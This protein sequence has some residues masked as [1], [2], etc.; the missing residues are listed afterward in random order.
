MMTST[1]TRR[2]TVTLL[3]H[4]ES[5]FNRD[6][7]SGPDAAITPQGAA[8]AST[9]SGDYD[10][11]LV[12]AMRRARETWAASG[13]AATR[14]EF[15]TLA[16]ERQS[17]T[18]CNGLEGEKGAGEDDEAFAFRMRQ[19]WDTILWLG[20]RHDRILALTGKHVGNCQSITLD[21]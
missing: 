8:Q 4:A 1:P 13:I 17:K 11:A 10:Y 15:T 19:L 3:R 5:T 6:G 9:L 7:E 16:R 2:S 12:S 18:P 21:L 20:T 14:V